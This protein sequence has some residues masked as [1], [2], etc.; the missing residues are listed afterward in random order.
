WRRLRLQRRRRGR[1]AHAA[2]HDHRQA[3]LQRQPDLP[4]RWLWQPAG[5]VGGD[6][7]ARGRPCQHGNRINVQAYNGGPL[8]LSHV[9]TITAGNTYF[10]VRDSNSRINL[11]GL[12]TFTGAIAGGTNGL[13]ARQS[14]TLT[15]TTSTLT[16]T[17]VG[18]FVDPTGV[19]TV[20]TL[21]L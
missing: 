11:S 2:G 13:D 20:G 7:L 8:D 4:G 18:V 21:Q 6:H 3:G 10:Q 15:L 19:I 5:P 16:V 12:T 14:G 9:D 1:R 17:N